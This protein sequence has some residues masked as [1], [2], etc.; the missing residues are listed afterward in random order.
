MYTLINGEKKIIVHRVRV[1]FR[2]RRTVHIDNAA[3]RP[4]LNQTYAMIIF[5][6]HSNTNY[7]PPQNGNLLRGDDGHAVQFG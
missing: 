5:Q 6:I 2:C 7:L 1:G 4:R 3:W